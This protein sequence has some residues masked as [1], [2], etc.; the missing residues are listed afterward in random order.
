M[1]RG[2]VA[3]LAFFVSFAVFG[4]EFRGTISGSVSDPTGALIPGA[5][6]TATEIRTGTKSR[7]VSDST[8]QYAIPFLA[9]GEYEIAA[10]SQGFKQAVRK[11]VQLGSGDH[12]VIDIRLEVGDTTQSVDVTSD[13]PIVDTANASVG[14]AITTRQVED[15]P[16]NGRTPMMLAQLAIGVI[17]TGNPS[18]VHP[19]DNG[20]AA[21]WSIGGAPKQTSELLLDGS[22]NA[23]WDSRMAYSPPQDAVQEVR[24]KAFD[25]DAAYGHT[26]SG[27]ANV[28]MKT[29]TNTFHG[30]M[31]EFTQASALDANGFFTNKLA[32]PVQVTHFNQYGL[33]AGGPVLFPKVFDG[34]NKLFW[35]FAW[36]NLSDAQPNTNLTTVPTDLEKKG[37]FSA[38]LNAGSNYQIYN[39]YSAVLNG[40]AVNR[41]PFQNNVIPSD[42][43]N[44]ISQ[45]YLKFYP[46]PNLPGLANGFDNFANSATTN[47]SYNNELGRVD[48]NMSDSSRMFFDVRHNYELQGKNNYFRNVATGTN[49]TRENWGV[50]LDEVYTFSPS[51]VLDMRANFTRLN[52]IHTEPSAGFDPTQL[53]FPPYVAATAQFLQMPFIGFSGSCGSQTSFQ[54]LG[55]SSAAKTPSQSY[56]LFGDLIKIKGNHTLKFGA[57]VRQYRLN[58]IS[59]GSSAG[60]FTFGN[61]WTKASSSSSAVT[62]LGQDFASFL[63]GLPTSGQFDVSSFGSYYSYYF[64]SF[65]QDDWR[66]KKNLTLN[67]GI[68]FD[69]DAPY[70]EKYGRTVNGFAVNAANPVSQ[71]A[72]AA[73]AKN[74]IPQIPVGSFAVPGGLTFASPS[75]RGIFENTSHLLSPR[76][77][78]AWSPGLL[79][80][81]TVIRGGFGMFVSPTTIANLSVNGNYSST[82]IIDQEGFSQ[83]T[84]FV[85]PSNFLTPSTTLSIRFPTASSNPSAQRKGSP[86]SWVRPCSF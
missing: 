69:R 24:I 84:Q 78:F 51:T 46:E 79:H 53:G 62:A 5:K 19:F 22:P 11:A 72:I 59:Y 66:V 52:E 13:A 44:S 33:T 55:D 10:Q 17:A 26:G 48:Y 40:S 12:P 18:L 56:Q 61:N 63:L 30:T 74:P 81:K 76:F 37:D 68:R 21:A 42:R 1:R 58:N 16:L 57:D 80:G 47:D 6:I 75:N 34:R 2:R 4:Q 82:P 73:Y 45:A 3:V 27:T 86:P 14:Q 65:V 7:T 49:L 9:P 70:N 25:S 50:T 67:I 54:C 64:S 85:T 35:F 29:G 23:T 43:L 38:L 71:A 20:A 31:Y 83:S 32:Q 60:T 36:E 77:G 28:V 41:Q 15:F 39:P 8:G